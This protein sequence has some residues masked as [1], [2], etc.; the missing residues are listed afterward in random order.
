MEH[1]IDALVMEIQSGAS[2]KRE[3]LWQQLQGEV[4]TQA[5]LWARR[6]QRRRPSLCTEDLYQCGY[7]AL[8]HAVEYYFP[9]G[10]MPFLPWF[11]TCLRLEFAR[12]SGHRAIRVLDAMEQEVPGP[13]L[14]APLE[15]ALNTLPKH[16]HQILYLRYLLGLSQR[17]TG[18]L[19][20][21][22]NKAVATQE[23]A[24]LRLLRNSSYSPALRCLYNRA[25]NTMDT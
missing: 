13:I 21:L 18:L 24:A 15:Q 7:I 8:C 5:R 11:F 2:E 14:P 16:L 3:L 6:F 17:E 25:A 20:K 4:Q 23:A 9:D 10:E 12:V 22:S 1:T 19:M